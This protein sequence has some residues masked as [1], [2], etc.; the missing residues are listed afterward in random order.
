[1]MNGKSVPLATCFAKPLLPSVAKTR[2]R[3][4][5]RARVG[6]VC[7]VNHPMTTAT[8]QHEQQ[9]PAVVAR[10]GPISAAS[11][12]GRLRLRTVAAPYPPA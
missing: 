1:M 7:A 6:C 3:G 9:L 8:Q 10:I 5:P 12:P 2:A 11:S 4:T